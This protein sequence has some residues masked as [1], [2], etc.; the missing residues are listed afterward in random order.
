MSEEI[1]KSDEYEEMAAA[2]QCSQI[3]IL[4]NVLSEN[5][6]SSQK[7]KEIV[8]SFTLKFGVVLD[9]YWLD[10]EEGKI[11]P[12]IAFSKKH[13]DYE[14]EAFYFNEGAFSFAEYAYGNI[15]WYYEENSGKNNPQLMGVIDDD[16]NP[17]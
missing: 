6:I 4:D 13:Q 9:Q 8:E 3:Q 10:S 7:A 11:F 1:L 17:A 16:G 2:F 12:T 5:G 14:P 15:S